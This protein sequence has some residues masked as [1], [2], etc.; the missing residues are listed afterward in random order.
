MTDIG[1]N[2]NGASHGLTT[3][4]VSNAVFAATGMRIRELPFRHAGIPVKD[5]LS[6]PAR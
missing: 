3:P 1:L 2:L 4:A 5:P 6:L